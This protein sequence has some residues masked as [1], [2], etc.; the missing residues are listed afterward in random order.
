[1]TIDKIIL[2]SAA[3]ERLA[4]L[5]HRLATPHEIRNLI[6]IELMGTASSPAKAAALWAAKFNKHARAKTDVVWT[7]PPEVYQVANTWHAYSRS[8][9]A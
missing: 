7:V 2:N 1:M 5:H 8:A 9:F 6:F 3:A 4:C